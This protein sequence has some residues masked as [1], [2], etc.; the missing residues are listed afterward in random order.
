MRRPLRSIQFFAKVFECGQIFVIT[1]DVTQQPIQF[2]ESCIVNSAVFLEAV[3]G[4]RPELIKIP[5]RLRHANDRHIEMSA[6]Y[7]AL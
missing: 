6:L 4:S 1:I 5:T 3:K 7:H 2:F